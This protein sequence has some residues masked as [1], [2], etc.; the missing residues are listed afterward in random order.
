MRG[1]V[2]ARGASI[3]RASCNAT[4]PQRSLQA[5][6]PSF[7]LPSRLF[8]LDNNMRLNLNKTR[9]PTTMV[10][11]EQH[12]RRLNSHCQIA[13]TWSS[14]YNRERN[15]RSCPSSSSSSSSSVT[16]L[17]RRYD[18][19]KRINQ[20]YY[21]ILPIYSPVKCFNRITRSFHSRSCSVRRNTSF[22]PNIPTRE[23]IKL[24]SSSYSLSSNRFRRA[25]HSFIQHYWSFYLLMSS[26]VVRNSISMQ[27]RSKSSLAAS[28]VSLP[29]GSE[30]ETGDKS[31]KS[32]RNAS[33]SSRIRASSDKLASATESTRIDPIPVGINVK[34][35]RSV[36]LRTPNQLVDR[37]RDLLACPS[38]D[39]D[40]IWQAYTK[41]AR[42]RR[43]LA[44]LE[45][46]D[47][48]AI[49]SV[50]RN[51]TVQTTTLDDYEID[52]PESI[53]N[54]DNSSSDSTPTVHERYR[55]RDQVTIKRIVKVVNNMRLMNKRLPAHEYASLIVTCGRCQH[56][57]AVERI[58]QQ[59]TEDLAPAPPPPG[60]Y[61]AMMSVCL[62][63]KRWSRAIEL[64]EQLIHVKWTP[65]RGQCNM[66]LR[67]YLEQGDYHSATKLFQSMQ[68]GVLPAELLHTTSSSSSSSVSISTTSKDLLTPIASVPA[69]SSN[70]K[71][72]IVTYNTCISADIAAG[73]W[74][75][76][77]SRYEAMVQ[78]G[79]PM[80]DKR[81][82]RL[83][84]EVYAHNNNRTGFMRVWH[85]LAK[86]EDGI[87]VNACKS[88]LKLL[89]HRMPPVEAVNVLFEQVFINNND[90]YDGQ[91]LARHMMLYALTREHSP[92]TSQDW[93]RNKM[94]FLRLY[95]DVITGHHHGRISND[96]AHT[97]MRGLLKY[98]A[99]SREMGQFLQWLDINQFDLSGTQWLW[100]LAYLNR[101]ESSNQTSEAFAKGVLPSYLQSIAWNQPVLRQQTTG[102]HRML[103]SVLADPKA[104]PSDSYSL[105]VTMQRDGYT[106]DSTTLALLAHWSTDVTVLHQLWESTRRVATSTATWPVFISSFAR[107]GQ[108]AMA[109][110]LLG[111]LRGVMPH[112]RVPMHLYLQLMQAY[113][114]LGNVANVRQIYRLLRVDGHGFNLKA[115]TIL[116][117]ARARFSRPIPVR[118]VLQQLRL[119]NLTPDLPLLTVL[120]RSSLR[121]ANLIAV[122][123]LLRLMREQRIAPDAQFTTTLLAGY[124]RLQGEQGVEMALRSLHQLYSKSSMSNDNDNNNNNNASIDIPLNVVH[125]NTILSGIITRHDPTLSTSD[126][127]LGAMM[128]A[129]ST[130][131]IF[132]RI[133]Q[134]NQSVSN[135]G[136]HLSTS[137]MSRMPPPSL[138][139]FKIVM[140]AHTRY[141]RWWAVIRWWRRW[142]AYLKRDE[143]LISTQSMN[144]AAD[145][146]RIE[147][148]KPDA[149]AYQMVIQ[150]LQSVGHL[151]EAQRLTKDAIKQGLFPSHDE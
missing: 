57:A 20:P 4:L 84:L 138:R 135:D 108:V 85:R 54:D 6:P 23:K 125:W 8:R 43:L 12:K 119:Q 25:T 144:E 36:Q 115:A 91:L 56:P 128:N 132:P 63:L 113:R 134:R 88:A 146:D 9:P 117:D 37:L 18:S 22:N 118:Q 79:V 48:R 27:R 24:L 112:H 28:S 29:D 110:S 143:H 104:V 11:S 38:S 120:L 60:V 53:T 141:Q 21:P 2:C 149:V 145:A 44:M 32:K 47:F 42:W 100:L 147:Q 102:Y 16:S 148:I 107:H 10:N 41:V 77:A 17:Q 94:E 140:G 70:Y 89:E 62:H 123:Y 50:L 93:K 71:A 80:P 72:D 51:D 130:S 114:Q 103:I 96:L 5:G 14:S 90:C 58:F 139:T 151:Q 19:G 86:M 126:H 116:A 142:Q 150:A 124:S 131:T 76:A 30:V 39:V 49:L 75:E 67:A 99:S 129:A 78:T 136:E 111:Q 1:C 109:R 101:R 7:L 69:Q 61:T 3:G 64:F 83:L 92:V 13:A 31:T 95:S 122:N 82:F 40:T 133:E 52:V 46:V 35:Q 45:K 74:S 127:I 97:I 121:H 65:T 26:L 87:D 15:K 59:C 106:L 137:T 68:Q 105:L 34:R 66:A 73:R 81:T 55:Q 33:L 98:H